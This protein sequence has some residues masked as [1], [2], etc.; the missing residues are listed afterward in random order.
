MEVYRGQLRSQT[1]HGIMRSLFS[2]LRRVAVP[3]I[4]KGLKKSAVPF[5]KKQAKRLAPKAAKAG[6]N[7]LGDVVSKQKT[8]KEATKSRAREL[9]VEAIKTPNP[10]KRA[11]SA[12]AAPRRK[13]RK[14][15]RQKDIF[16]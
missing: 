9:A 7:V 11:H 1:G 5:I 10:K 14:T 3:A 15:Q 12:R 16:D 4:K 8:F 13:R 2:V 6:L